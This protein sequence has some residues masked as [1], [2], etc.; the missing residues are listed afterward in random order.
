MQFG[1][2]L[3]NR[4]V[5]MGAVT[6]DQMLDLAEV[7]DRSGRFNFV[8]VGDSLLG[9]PRTRGTPRGLFGNKGLITFHSKSVRS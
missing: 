5:L 3:P 8:W 7:A 6:S 4:G 9:K 2:T 1:L